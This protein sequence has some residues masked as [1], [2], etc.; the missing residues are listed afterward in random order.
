MWG[1]GFRDSPGQRGRSGRDGPVGPQK[2]LETISLGAYC[3]YFG[4]SALWHETGNT[5]VES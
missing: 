1:E 4:F 5:S 2:S 3:K